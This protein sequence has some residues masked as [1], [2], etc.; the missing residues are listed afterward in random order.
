MWFSRGPSSASGTFRDPTPL[1][2]HG[3]PAEIHPHMRIPLFFRSLC[4]LIATTG[5]ATAAEL[6][7][8]AGELVGANDVVVEGQRYD[9]V[10]VDGVCTSLYDGCDEDADFTFPWTA[11]D[12]HLAARQALLDQVFVGQFDTEPQLTRGCEAEAWCWIYFP[13]QK[14]GSAAAIG[15]VYVDNDELEVRD[16]ATNQGSGSNT[17]DTTTNASITWAVWSGPLGPANPPAVPVT[18]FVGLGIVTGACL[19][20]WRSRPRNDRS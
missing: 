11:P 8:D 10:F 13:V 5:V 3:R 12:G 4:L 6:V 2:K 1:S 15:I 18:P 16:R 17:Q 20:V 19:L 9:V 14:I 7:V